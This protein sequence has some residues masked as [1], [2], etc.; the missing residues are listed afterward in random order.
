[1]RK[2]SRCRDCRAVDVYRSRPRNFIE[3][4]IVPLLGLRPMR[5]ADCFRRS[6]QRFFVIMRERSEADVRRRFVA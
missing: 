6:Y 4:Y 2:P 1:M 3:K 5:C